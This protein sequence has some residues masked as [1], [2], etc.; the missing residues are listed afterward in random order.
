LLVPLSPAWSWLLEHAPDTLVQWAAR[1]IPRDPRPHIVIGERLL[2][3]G[4]PR[5]ALVHFARAASCGS[6]EFRL[7]VALADA[8]RAAG[9]HEKAA[10][11]A[12]NLLQ[13][14]PESG[15]LHR[16]LGQCQLEMGQLSEGLASLEQATRL[17][18]HDADAW[19]ALAEARLG[20]EGFRPETA[21][22][23]ESGLRQNPG[24]DGLRYG[25]VET[26]VG[27]G[28]YEEAEALLRNLPKQSVPE[29]PKTKELYA[30]A[31]SAW[32]T[33]LHRLR[34]DGVRRSQARRALEHALT[35]APRHP[36]THYEL[37][38][39]LEEDR[40]WE[41]SRK[42]L[43]TATQLRPYAHP[44]W[45]HLAR[46]YRRLGLRKQADLAEARFTVLVSTFAAV[47]R[48]S[49]YL[50]EHPDDVD[51]RLRLAQILIQREDWGA[52]AV[53]LSLVLRDHPRHPEANRLLQH[54]RGMR[55]RASGMPDGA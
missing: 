44:F 13:V 4:K 8:M 29:Y 51:R 39:L 42:F 45:Y 15:R 50:D 25:L 20:I 21:K 37:G 49:R 7:A 53:H 47:N 33:V 36:E 26:Y 14:D 34:P 22:V 2:A 28:R 31:W 43:E 23:W 12:R 38:L 5:P 1:W 55:G 16:V 46:V 19:I 24:Q 3:L 48:E 35:L 32:G 27:L 52:A 54:L 30:R 9:L 41:E 18:P 11:Q 6:Q 40:R 10:F 17:A